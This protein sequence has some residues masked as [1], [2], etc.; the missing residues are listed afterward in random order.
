[1]ADVVNM[2]GFIKN[3]SNLGFSNIDYICE[4]IDDALSASAT[5][6]QF[7]INTIKKEIIVVDNGC[8]MSHDMLNIAHIFCN[9]SDSSNDKHGRFGMGRKVAIVNLSGCGEVITI[10]MDG[11]NCINQVILDYK[12]AIMT[13]NLTINP[14]EVTI[15]SH[16]IWEKYSIDKDKPGTITYIKCN[17]YIAFNELVK[18]IETS[19]IIE[20][21]CFRYALGST[22]NH[23]IDKGIKISFI[24]DEKETYNIH[25]INPLCLDSIPDGNKVINE[26]H[27]YMN[28]E[29]SVIQVCYITLDNKLMYID[30]T[31]STRGKSL[32]YIPL[33]ND[34]LIGK[35]QLRHAWSKRWLD[36][37]DTTFINMG[38]KFIADNG[39]NCIEKGKSGKGKSGIAFQRTKLGGVYIERNKRIISR[40]PIEN[41]TAGSTWRYPCYTSSRH[42]LSFDASKEMDEMFKVMINKSKIEE[43]QINKK[44]WNMVT[45]LNNE[46][47]KK[48][49]CI[50]NPENKKSEKSEESEES[51][52]EK[53]FRLKSPQEKAPQE[54]APQEKQP[55][56]KPPDEKPP[57]EKAPQEKPPDEKPPNSKITPIQQL[58]NHDFTF[59]KYTNQN[60][61]YIIVG[62]DNKELYKVPYIGNFCNWK[63]ILDDTLIMIGPERFIEYL[64]E[65]IKA[66]NML[67]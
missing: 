63:A 56:E 33:K 8:G 10:S 48:I 37:Q 57:D 45:K 3:M 35:L 47:V 29:S 17:D 28:K 64:K 19:E 51:E 59:S 4:L 54:K 58:P 53:A 67:N 18:G 5:I 41:P 2:T 27:M 30:N 49:C 55:D 24:I 31:K 44:L 38:L 6:I 50:E 22:Y 46:F 52:E 13:N 9:T 14:G 66:N 11:T 39:E 7:Y 15:S 36:I 26:I 20:E 23:I 40:F 16:N 32:A 65:L 1:M 60:I 21:N 12:K 42:E 61:N 62:R 43:S 25:A 34:I